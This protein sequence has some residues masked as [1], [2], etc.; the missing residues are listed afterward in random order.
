MHKVVALIGMMGSGKSSTARALAAHLGV[1]WADTDDA[2]RAATGQSPADIITQQGEG[3]FRLLERRALLQT[4]AAAPG[5]LAT[6]GGIVLRADNRR[7]LRQRTV[8]V[9]LQADA[10]LLWQRV[11]A[12]TA[13]RPLLDE[14]GVARVRALLAARQAHYQRVAHHTVVQQAGETPQQIAEK[15]A[16][17]LAAG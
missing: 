15:I 1:A 10:A 13:R 14:G 8:A 12:Q 7:T 3:A 6:G 17:A 11:Q 16:A 5:V 2:V 4:L 9:Y